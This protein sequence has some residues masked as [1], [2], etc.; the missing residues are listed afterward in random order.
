MGR[1]VGI[2]VIGALLGF[3]T[4]LAGPLGLFL[5]SVVGIMVFSISPTDL[6][7][8]NSGVLLAASGLTAS[9]LL[10]RVVLSGVRDPA[11]V[12]GPGT[13]ETFAAAVLLAIVRGVVA[14]AG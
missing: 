6:R 3:I 11:I 2:V 5:S 1:L 10:G 14:V 7:G 13:L 8:Q 9:L 4:L 12:L